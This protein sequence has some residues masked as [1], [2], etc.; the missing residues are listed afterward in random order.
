MATN[1]S[2]QLQPPASRNTPSPP[3]QAPL[4]S[5]E[6]RVS[7]NNSQETS[8]RQVQFL[9]PRKHNHHQYCAFKERSP[10]E[11]NFCTHQQEHFSSFLDADRVVLLPEP[12]D[13]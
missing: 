7:N 4:E 12:K 9:T 3:P 1:V 2:K 11:N 6:C 13:R 8:A 5:K 10:D